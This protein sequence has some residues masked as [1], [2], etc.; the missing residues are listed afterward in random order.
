MPVKANTG[1]V[2]G[3]GSP[4]DYVCPCCETVIDFDDLTYDQDTTCIFEC[5][6]CG[7][8]IT[9]K[10]DQLTVADV[11][12]DNVDPAYVDAP[13]A[14]DKVIEYLKSIGFGDDEPDTPV[15]PADQGTPKKVWKVCRHGHL[16]EYTARFCQ[17]CGAAL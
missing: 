8:E 1:T 12:A 9:M 4:Q 13:H 14:R 10:I 7:L 2:L 15:P 11:R 6:V 16:S 5:N 3:I 17:E